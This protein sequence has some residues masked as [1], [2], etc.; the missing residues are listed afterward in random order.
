MHRC[1]AGD[2]GT[3]WWIGN[4]GGGFR[5]GGCAAAVGARFSGFE[6]SRSEMKWPL[7]SPTPA[8]DAAS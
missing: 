8:G 2:G 5:R 4:S 6:I 7:P 1:S 3:K